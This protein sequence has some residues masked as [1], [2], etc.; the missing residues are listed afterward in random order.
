M[1]LRHLRHRDRSR[2]GRRT[3]DS[4]RDCNTGGAP[5]GLLALRA[6]GGEFGRSRVELASERFD[7][8]LRG[9]FE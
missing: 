1:A 2:R 5:F 3:L 4:G 9:A 8:C 7:L 6:L